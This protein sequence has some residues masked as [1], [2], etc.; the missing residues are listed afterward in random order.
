MENFEN[1]TQQINQE[2]LE[3]VKDVMPILEKLKTDGSFHE[4]TVN[5]SGKRIKVGE[6]VIDKKNYILQKLYGVSQVDGVS[7]IP[8]E[9]EKFINDVHKTLGK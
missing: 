8:P 9:V 6:W 3:I 2:A 7:G 1:K 4:T 5:N